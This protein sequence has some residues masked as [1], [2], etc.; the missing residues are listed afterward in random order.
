MEQG[1]LF[2]LAIAAIPV[3]AGGLAYLRH[4]ARRRRDADTLHH[5]E[6]SRKHLARSLYPVIDADIYIGSCLNA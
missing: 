4:L 5:P 1:R 6:E 2:V 3:L